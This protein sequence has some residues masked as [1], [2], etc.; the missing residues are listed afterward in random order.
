MQVSPLYTYLSEIIPI[1]IIGFISNSV[2]VCVC[3]CVCVWV[4]G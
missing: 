3:V 2:C 1:L 4:I